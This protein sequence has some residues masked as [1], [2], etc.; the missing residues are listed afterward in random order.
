MEFIFMLTHDDRTV[1]NAMEVYDQIRDTPLR[2]IGFKDVGATKGRLKEL[3]EAMHDDRREVFLEVVSTSRDDELRSIEAALE[4]GVDYLL[5]GTHYDDALSL[6]DGSEMRYFPFPGTVV[7]HPSRLE[8]SKIEIADHARE[9]VSKP[10]VYGLDLLAYRHPTV[11]PPEL[12][13]AVIDASRRPVIAAG[14]V[15]REQRIRDLAGAGA[16]AF[17]IGGAIFEGVLPGA[18]SIAAQIEWAM[19]VAESP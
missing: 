10:G 13:R 12:T 16:W 5:G 7:G 11:D 1:D 15:D 2:L 4:V 19:E 6:I 3:T 17:T 18:P 9:L 8:G 14:S